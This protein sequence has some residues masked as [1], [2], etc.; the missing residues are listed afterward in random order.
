M[1]F[2]DDIEV[3][4]L[5]SEVQFEADPNTVYFII[6]SGFVGEL[7]CGAVDVQ[8]TSVPLGEFFCNIKR[9]AVLII[10]ICQRH[11][12]RTLCLT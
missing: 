6:L 8:L 10:A 1:V 3:G 12:L 11:V 4:T 7:D 5:L 9:K 2:N